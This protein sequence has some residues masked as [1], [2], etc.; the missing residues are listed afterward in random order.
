MREVSGGRGLLVFALAALVTMTPVLAQAQQDHL[1]LVQARS[2]AEQARL[3]G[4][5][6]A[7]AAVNKPLWFAAGCLGGG[8]VVS[9][10]ASVYEPDPPATKLLGKSPEYIAAYT[11]TYRAEAKSLQIRWLWYGSGTTLGC[12]GVFLLIMALTTPGT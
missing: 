7:D 8:I 3:D 2:D 11:D 10:I 5:R 4:R 9:I 6:D 12:L 1:R